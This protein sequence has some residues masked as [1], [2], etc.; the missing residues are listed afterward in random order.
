MALEMLTSRQISDARFA[1][2]QTPVSSASSQPGLTAKEVSDLTGTEIVNERLVEQSFKDEVDINTI[3][4]RFG[5]VRNLPQWGPAG[6]YGD[7]T[8]IEDY[9]S[10]ERK[11]AASREAFLQMPPEV[12]ARFKND[13]G[14]LIRAAR[15]MPSGDFEKLFDVVAE[16]QLAADMK[17]SADAVA[18]KPV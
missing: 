13:P 15:E 2:L 17:A 11:I 5:G 7:F 3:V 8:D 10:A 4:R 12:R 9:E 6:V 14:E 18:A 16:P 1:S